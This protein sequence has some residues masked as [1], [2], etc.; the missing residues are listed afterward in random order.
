M[1]IDKHG[2]LFIHFHSLYWVYMYVC[3]IIQILIWHSFYKRVSYAKYLK[4]LDFCLQ[5]FK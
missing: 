5:R 3:H 4:R 1:N 2:P